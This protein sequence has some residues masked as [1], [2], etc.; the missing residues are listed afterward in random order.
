MSAACIKSV[1]WCCVVEWDD[2]FVLFCLVNQVFDIRDL[3]YFLCSKIKGATHLQVPSLILRRLRRGPVRLASLVS[4]NDCRQELENHPQCNNV[5][6]ILYEESP[7]VHLLVRNFAEL[8]FQTK[9][10]KGTQLRFLLEILLLKMDEFQKPSIETN[11][12]SSFSSVC[13]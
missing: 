7:V 6:I 3:E 5:T 4:D 1:V 9:V 12:W 8:G 10:L 2:R 11:I 13:R